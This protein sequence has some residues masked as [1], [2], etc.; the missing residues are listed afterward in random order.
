M[1]KAVTGSCTQMMPTMMTMMP[2]TWTTQ[3][4]TP[5]DGQSMIAYAHYQMSQKAGVAKVNSCWLCVDTDDSLINESCTFLPHFRL[6]YAMQCLRL[7]ANQ[8]ISSLL[9]QIGM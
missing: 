8:L 2:T 3:M 1:I 7:L 9:I 5:H 6:H 4:T